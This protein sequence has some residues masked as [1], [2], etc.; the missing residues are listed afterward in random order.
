M[1]R[2][3]TQVIPVLEEM[4]ISEK[5]GGRELIFKDQDGGGGGDGRGDDSNGGRGL[6][7]VTMI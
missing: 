2:H 7:M 5:M 6:V 1:G 3:G 4:I